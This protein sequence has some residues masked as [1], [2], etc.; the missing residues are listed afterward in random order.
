VVALERVERG[1]VSGARLLVARLSV[2]RAGLTPAQ[3][4]PQERHQETLAEH[5][6]IDSRLS[7]EYRTL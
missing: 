5:E 4:A 6:L 3:E 1:G 7:T 2:R